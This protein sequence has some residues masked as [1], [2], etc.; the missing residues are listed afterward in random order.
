MKL[1]NTHFLHPAIGTYIDLVIRLMVT[2]LILIFF[3]LNQW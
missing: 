3:G 1:K 2:G